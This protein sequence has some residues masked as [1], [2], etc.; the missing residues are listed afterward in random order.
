MDTN[1][2]VAASFSEGRE[3]ERAPAPG[4]P[5]TSRPADRFAG[6]IEGAQETTRGYLTE[7]RRQC[8]ASMEEA[9]EDARRRRAEMIAEADAKLS[10]LTETAETAMSD[11]D[12]LR[13]GLEETISRLRGA[14]VTLQHQANGLGGGEIA[15]DP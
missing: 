1:D 5:G 14:S 6:I 7:V 13:R 11:M 10:A 3:E 9:E 8:D 15:V 4:D 2:E 12:E